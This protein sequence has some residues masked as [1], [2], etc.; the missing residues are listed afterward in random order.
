MADYR[1]QIHATRPP[2]GFVDMTFSADKSLSVAWALAPTEAERAALL[3]IHRHA[4][5]DT[6]A[7]AETQLGFARRGQGGGEGVETGELGWISFQ[8]YTARPAVDIERR[9][10]ARPGLHRH[11]RGAVAD[12]GP[13]AS[14][15]CD[16]VQ[17]RP[18]RQRAYRRPR[19]RPAGRAGQGTGC[20]LPCQCR[21]PGP[22]ARHRDRARRAH[23]CGTARRYPAFGAR[24]VQQADD[25]SAG[26]GARVRGAQGDR[27]GR[28]HRRAE[29]C[30]VEGWGGG[31]PAGK[32]RDGGGPRTEK[33]FRGMA[34]ASRG[35]SY[36][37]R[38]VLRPDEVIA[39]TGGR[40]SAI[41]PPIA[42]PCHCSRASSA[43][44]PYWTAR[45]C[46]RSRR[47][48]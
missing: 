10:R 19:S 48:H 3:D 34:R 40:T 13:A 17:Q 43:A 47:G 14:H 44:V 26:C 42:R 22:A 29:D 45:N 25:R 6:M 21:G 31:N 37:H 36:R 2:V 28:D 35:A 15:P 5:A 12:G 18:D 24:A 20:G 9:D 11:P 38:S 39:R 32:N 33:R 27:L 7:Y 41:K 1:R 4:V 30:L 16:G 46:A 23:R 8:H